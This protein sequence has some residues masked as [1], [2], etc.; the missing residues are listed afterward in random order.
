[1]S[2]KN[3]CFVEFDKFLNINI[4][5]PHWLKKGIF[6]ILEIYNDYI[7]VKHSYKEQSNKAIFMIYG[8]KWFR[9]PIVELV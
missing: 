6:F 4:G 1:M 5:C 8:S 2:L 7:I 3:I 9:M